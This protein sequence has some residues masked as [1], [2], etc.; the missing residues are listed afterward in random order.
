[1][2]SEGFEIIKNDYV[3]S[4]EI[5]DIWENPVV[6][7]IVS[8]IPFFSSEIEYGLGKALEIR[9]KKKMEQL[10]EIILED[11]SVTIDDIND[12]DCIMEFAKTIDVVKKLIRNEK[13]KYLAR[14]LKNSIKDEDRD[15]DEFEELLNKIDT[16][17]L[18]ELDLLHL[19]YE[20]E[21]R[22]TF[23]DRTNQSHF[24]P[25][26]SWKAFLEKAKVKYELNDSEIISKMLG[27]M[28]TGFCVS[29]WRTYLNARAT[30]VMYTAPEY[31]KLLERI[32]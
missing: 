29:E 5:K 32:Q 21:Q 15:V 1:M 4:D 9:Q 23:Q 24:N 28:R 12:V 31:H 7:C 27:I 14:L 11:D 19:M 3:V 16:L 17:S 10:F 22:I 20:E 8:H 25:E 26:E 6:K 13:V 30:L 2:M 18:R